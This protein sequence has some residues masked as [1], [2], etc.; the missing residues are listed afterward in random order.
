M[1]GR[2]ALYVL[3][4]LGACFLLERASRRWPSLRNELVLGAAVLGAWVALAA[5]MFFIADHPLAALGQAATGLV[6]VPLFIGAV[7][8]AAYAVPYAFGLAVL[9][10]VLVA[11]A[12]RR[13]R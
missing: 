10:V 7:V 6:F 12:V 8:V 2:L 9:P 3:S 4:L 13:T 5:V 1:I 11:R